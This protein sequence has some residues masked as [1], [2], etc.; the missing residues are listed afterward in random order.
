MGAI[1]LAPVRAST[2]ASRIDAI[3][4]FELF[5]SLFFIALI[6]TLIVYF[7]IRYRRRSE[8]EIP[9]YIGR[10]YGLEAA[11]AIIPFILMLV[12]FFWGAGIYTNLKQPLEH[13]LEIHV[14]GKQWMWK[15]EHPDG[16][17][18]IDEL[19]VPAGEP[20]KLI[21]TSQDVIHDFF[22]PEFRI[23]QDVLPGS[24]VT[25]WFTATRPGIYHIF[26]AQYCGT[27]HAKMVGRVVVMSPSDYQAWRAGAIPSQSPAAAGAKLFA[28]YGC[29]TCHGQFAPT[30]AGLYGSS[31]TLQDGSRVKADEAYFRR[32]IEDPSSQIV[33]GYPII[34][35]S[36][37]GQLSEEQLIQLIAYMKSLAVVQNPTAGTTQPAPMI[38]PSTRPAPGDQPSVAPNHPPAEAPYPIQPS[39]FRK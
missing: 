5:V 20:V 25:E 8:D 35:P 18:E 6:F 30:L 33:A 27:D 38:G 2:A 32:S 23:K 19:H 29:A 15:I 17:R 39:P 26:C 3:F 10:H 7:V 24:Y 28:T 1:P 21:M 37:K 16:V 14:I 9:P 12:M 4:L 31:V 36:Y 11:W 34:M 22:L 13:G